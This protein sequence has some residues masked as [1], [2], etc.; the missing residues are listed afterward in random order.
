MNLLLA[1][2]LTLQWDPNPP[3]DN[4]ALYNVHIGIQSMLAGNPS[5][6]D[7]PVVAPTTVFTAEVEYEQLYFFTVTAVNFD[8]VESGYSN[9][10]QHIVTLPTPS[11]TPVATPT[12][13]PTV[14]PTPTATPVPTPTPAA[15]PW[16]WWWRNYFNR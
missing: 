14:L 9:E 6:V 5:L 16:W 15:T 2:S 4:V 1:V 12:P 3:E 13:A 8:G 11:P 10:V 7:Y